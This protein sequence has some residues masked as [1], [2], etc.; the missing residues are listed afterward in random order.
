VTDRRRVLAI[1]SRNQA[2]DGD[3]FPLV[4][5]VRDTGPGIPPTS[6]AQLFTAFHTT[7]VDGMGMGLSICRS[8]VEAHGGR[9]S[10]QT[11]LEYGACFVV[12]LPA[13]NEAAS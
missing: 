6:M 1:S 4:L 8:I 12:R 3:G 9:I 5:E 13:L 2:P 11:D 7:K 10:V